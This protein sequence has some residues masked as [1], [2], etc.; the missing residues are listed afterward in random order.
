MGGLADCD[1]RIRKRPGHLG[2]GVNDYRRA[3]LRLP[4]AP[5]VEAELLF[6]QADGGDHIRDI[7]VRE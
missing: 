5:A 2:T 7:Q 4:A 3:I 1:G 6:R